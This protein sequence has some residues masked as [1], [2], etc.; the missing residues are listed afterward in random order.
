MTP[1]PCRSCGRPLIWGVTMQGRRMPVDAKPQGKRIVLEPAIKDDLP[2]LATVVDVY[3]SHFATCPNAEQHR[4]AR[5]PAQPKP[6]GK[7]R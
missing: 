4:K 7:A 2:P 6:Q 1:K 5:T 3:V